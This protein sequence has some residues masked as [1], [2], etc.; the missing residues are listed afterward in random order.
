M[1]SRAHTSALLAFL[2]ADPALASVVFDGM[3]PGQAPPRYVLVF[4]QSMDHEVD[5]MAG[6]QRPLV[7]RHT[8][9]CVGSVPAEAQWLADKVSSRLVGARI[10]VPDRA[11]SPVRHESGD[12]MR[13]DTSGTAPAVY[14]LA[15]DYVWQSTP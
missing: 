3:V 6:R 13:M 2:R 7:A 11:S 1:S 9:H 4:A 15:D 5:R 14:F 10:P 8:I 12:P